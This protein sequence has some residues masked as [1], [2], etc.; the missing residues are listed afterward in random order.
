MSGIKKMKPAAK[1][2]WV[3]ALR[4]NGYTQGEGGLRI[5]DAAGAVTH[6]CLGVLSDIFENETGGNGRMGSGYLADD[7]VTWAGLEGDSPLVM[8]D[9]KTMA[10][11]EINDNG[12][13]FLEIA[14]I[15]EEQL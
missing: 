6:C 10:L 5:A 15:I 7:V 13:S 4:G 3:K 8:N 9:G 11:S 2:K 12:C 14:D 1:D